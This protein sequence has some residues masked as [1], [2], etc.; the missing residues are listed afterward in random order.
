MASMAEG[1]VPTIVLR[2]TSIDMVNHPPHYERGPQI[3]CPECG[4]V[5][6]LQHIEVFRYIKDS[7]LA[8]AFKYIWRVA[9]GGKDS[10]NTAKDV[11]DI[12]KAG[13]Y[14]K[15]FEENPV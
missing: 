15:D 5:R 2:D 7:R 6:T 13:F 11:Q 10:G 4:H 12:G 9:F 14:L 1:R 8:T 3:E